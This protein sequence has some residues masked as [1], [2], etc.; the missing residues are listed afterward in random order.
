M[1]TTGRALERLM[2]MTTHEGVQELIDSIP[3]VTE[4][5]ELIKTAE[6]FRTLMH[7]LNPN[8][9]MLPGPKDI[10]V[11]ATEVK[12]PTPIS[13]EMDENAG[14]TDEE[15]AEEDHDREAYRRG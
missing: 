1:D 13:D 11:E 7:K 12:P 8:M 9:P 3:T 6:G 4:T 2:I 15:E 10:V 14:E 5:L